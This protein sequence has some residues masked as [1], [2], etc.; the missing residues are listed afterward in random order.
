MGGNQSAT[1][2]PLLALAMEQSKHPFPSKEPSQVLMN[3]S[4]WIMGRVCGGRSGTVS[5]ALEGLRVVAL[6]PLL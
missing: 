2:N 1:S 5:G 4:C 6:Y 3:F